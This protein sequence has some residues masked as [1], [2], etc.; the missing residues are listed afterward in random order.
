MADASDEW[1]DLGDAGAYPA[2]LRAL[3]GKHGVYAIRIKPRLFGLV[4]PEVVYVGESHTR[5]LYETLTR[6]FQQWRRGKKWW[7]GKFSSEA[8]DPGH[9]YARGDV[10]VRVKVTPSKASAVA[11]QDAWIRRLKPRDN[12]AGV[13]LEAAPF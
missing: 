1:R 4:G 13:E 7:V 12:R 5:R 10:E 9:T 3:K 6:H 2:W 11:L 8:T